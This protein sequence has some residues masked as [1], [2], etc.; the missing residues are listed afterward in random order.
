MLSS[1]SE[2]SDS[3]TH[4]VPKLFPVGIGRFFDERVDAR[5]NGAFVGQVPGDASLV[6]RRG[7]TDE[8]GVV[9]EA[10]LGGVAFGL[11]SSRVD[12]GVIRS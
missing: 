11:Q 8:G 10:V 9:D 12:E 5:S 3:L 4:L 1:M 2:G 6:L 7:S